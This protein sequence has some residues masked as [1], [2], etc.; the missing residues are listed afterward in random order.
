MF[1]KPKIII[2]MHIEGKPIKHFLSLQLH[3]RFNAH[4]QFELR[5]EHGNLGLPGMISLDESRDFVGR[6]L[7]LS[8]G[9]DAAALQDFSGLITNVSISQSNGFQGVLL[10]SGYSPTIL[11]D[12]GADL[13]SYLNHSLH[14][15][16][17]AATSDLNDNILQLRVNP[18]RRTALDYVI[19]Y[20]ESDFQFLNRLSA[21]YYEWFYYDGV[22]LNFG[23][24]EELPQLT[25]TYGQEIS[26]LN[27]GIQVAPI[28]HKRFYYDPKDDEMLN[29]QSAPTSIGHPDLQHAVD[30]SNNLYG[31]VFNQPASTRIDSFSDLSD[32]VNYED[33]AHISQLQR[34]SGE[35]DSPLMHLASELRIDTSIRQEMCE[36][37]KDT[38]GRFLVTSVD[39]YF[40][41]NGHYSNHFEG[42]TASAERLPVDEYYRP[43]P[44]LQ[45]ADVLRNDDPKGQGRIK[46]RLKWQCQTNDETEWLR[47]LTPDAGSS[48]QVQANRGL[49]VIPEVGDQVVVAFE[50]GNIARPLVL[51]SVFSG[52][53]G[54]GGGGGNNLKSLSSKSGNTVTLN[55]GDG[56][57]TVA[58]PSGNVVKLHGDG[59]VSITAPNKI[60]FTSKEI[61]I[62]GT[63]KVNVFSESE[64]KLNSEDNME[65]LATNSLKQESKE[66]EVEGSQS[67]KMRSDTLI[68][69]EAP[70]VGINGKTQVKI[71]S[72]ALIDIS[73]DALCNVNAPAG[74][75]LN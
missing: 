6:R 48:D 16:V 70:K 9:Y 67:I 2:D 24:P 52:K 62:T 68:E 61:V 10:I 64:I 28:K 57:I 58:D 19:Q 18:T 1:E 7:S 40:G 11:I 17:N 35:S 15:I 43:A 45:L 4:H 47:V 51:G 13:G 36:F 34:V 22:N 63:D 75:N 21:E 5:I 20:R 26:S 41:A 32:L 69:K 3:Q 33:K 14:S 25:L 49:L 54:S 23:K 50:E 38:L 27:Y 12:R 30:R 31:K 74:I 44:D 56:S 60:E 42:I 46:V 65:F 71:S 53:T 39:H 72:S 8:F 66:V 37:V 73:S 59:T 55:D 29:S